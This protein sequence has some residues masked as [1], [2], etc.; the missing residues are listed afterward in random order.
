MISHCLGFYQ[1]YRG[2][3]MLNKNKKIEII[4]E[5]IDFFDPIDLL[6]L[7][8]PEDEYNVEAIRIE[9]EIDDYS[10][11]LKLMVVI[12]KVFQEMFDETLDSKTVHGIAIRIIK[13][14]QEASH[15]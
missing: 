15:N 2:R 12:E 5:A 1:L 13:S 8:A 14:F 7:G 3:Y 9:Q 11:R 4:K 6:A 10:D